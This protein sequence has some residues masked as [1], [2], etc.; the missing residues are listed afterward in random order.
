MQLKTAVYNISEKTL[1][2]MNCLLP[3][4]LSLFIWFA[5][6][7]ITLSMKNPLLAYHVYRP[8]SDTLF[9]S[10]ALIIGGGVLF[11]CSIANGDLKK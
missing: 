2:L 1:I 6:S 11:D 5:F 7:Y 8:I 3:L 4:I 9:T 10:L